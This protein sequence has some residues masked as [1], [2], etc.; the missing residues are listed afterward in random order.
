[1]MKSRKEIQQEL[2]VSIKN[3]MVRNRKNWD[4]VAVISPKKGKN[5]WTYREVYDSVENDKCLEDTDMNQID[6]MIRYYEWKE[7]QKKLGISEVIKDLKD[8]K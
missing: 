5:S 2:L 4:D 6:S 3:E 8:I 7:K 1:M